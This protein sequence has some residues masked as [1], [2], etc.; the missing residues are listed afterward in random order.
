MSL[1]VIVERNKLEVR[2]FAM[3]VHKYVKN[4]LKQALRD[5]HSIEY[6]LGDLMD[7]PPYFVDSTQEELQYLAEMRIWLEMDKNNIKKKLE[8]F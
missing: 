3:K 5:G 6:M 8:I 2:E 4:T 1:R 7:K